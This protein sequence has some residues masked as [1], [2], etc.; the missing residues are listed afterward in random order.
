MTP[1]VSRKQQKAACAELGRRKK[2][3]KPLMF[4]SMSMHELEKFCK[5][6]V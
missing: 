2:G 1:A 6:V 5:S 4:K 3:Q